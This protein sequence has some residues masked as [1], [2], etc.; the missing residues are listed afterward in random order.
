MQTDQTIELTAGIPAKSQKVPFLSIPGNPEV[1][2]L[3]RGWG[4]FIRL[5]NIFVI[6]LCA[7]GFFLFLSSPQTSGLGLACL[8][9]IV[10]SSLLVAVGGGLMAGRKSA[11]QG[12]TILA[13]LDL[14]SIIFLAL[15]V[16]ELGAGF[17]IGA[18]VAVL[19][20]LGPPLYVGYKNWGKFN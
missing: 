13:V 16:R 6:V 5:L 1:P 12:L 19:V 4:V 20:L 8:V 7:V 15:T 14:A 18:T 10:V 9:Q 3:V 17:G 2:A 11:L